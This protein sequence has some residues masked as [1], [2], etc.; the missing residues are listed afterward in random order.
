MIQKGPAPLLLT[1]IQARDDTYLKNSP[2]HT[3][4]LWNWT[5]WP[6]GTTQL[7]SKPTNFQGTIQ[8]AN[9]S[10]AISMQI[11]TALMKS[12]LPKSPSVY[13]PSRSVEGQQDHSLSQTS[14]SLTLLVRRQSSGTLRGRGLIPSLVL[15]PEPGPGAS[16]ES[17]TQCW[18]TD[19]SKTWAPR[20]VIT[21]ERWVHWFIYI[22][23]ENPNPLCL[24]HFW[25]PQVFRWGRAEGWRGDN[26][27][28]VENSRKGDEQQSG[29]MLKQ[30]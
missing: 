1:T 7:L 21:R 9:V 2:G 5:V 11:L 6:G 4:E 22:S 27:D 26:G 24:G 12:G 17:G 8:V 20:K 25:H 23:E 18:F 28:T 30:P 14:K 19:T 13:I 16:E 10:E 3:P 15:G 29:K